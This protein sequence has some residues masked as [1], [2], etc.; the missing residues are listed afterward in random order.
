MEEEVV[1]LLPLVKTG[2]IITLVLVVMEF[3]YLF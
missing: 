1:V 3:H 2:V